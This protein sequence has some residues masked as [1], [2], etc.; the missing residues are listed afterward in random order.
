VRLV[1]YVMNI[2]YYLDYLHDT[3]LLFKQMFLLKCI[4]KIIKS[5]TLILHYLLKKIFL[6]LFIY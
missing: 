6:K 3:F 5:L 1:L 4:L 2:S